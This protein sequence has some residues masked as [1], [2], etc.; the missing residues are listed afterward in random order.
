M[1]QFP[2]KAISHNVVARPPSERSWPARMLRFS[3]NKV[4]GDFHWFLQHR[5]VFKVCAFISKLRVD[6]GERSTSK[7]L[8][9]PSENKEK[10][11]AAGRT[12]QVGSDCF[13]DIWAGYIE[14]VIV[15]SPGAFVTSSPQLAAIDKES[16]P[17]SIPIPIPSSSTQSRRATQSYHILAP[18]PRSFVAYIRYR[19]LWYLQSWTSSVCLPIPPIPWDD[20]MQKPQPQSSA[21][22]KKNL[23]SP[24]KKV[25]KNLFQKTEKRW[26]FTRKYS[27]N[28]LSNLYH[29]VNDFVT[30]V[31]KKGTFFISKSNN[32][33]VAIKVRPYVTDRVN[34]R[35]VQYKPYFVKDGEKE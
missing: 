31:P 32:G 7:S 25:T 14:H 34:I 23:L 4:L 35:Q 3:I 27:P 19:L 24:A 2:A 33:T 1:E 9:S 20:L 15:G 6:S 30:H 17:P 10:L 26:S 12:F 16:L 13:C 18:S 22:K 28:E 21:Y 5:K 11:W 29:Y 8:L